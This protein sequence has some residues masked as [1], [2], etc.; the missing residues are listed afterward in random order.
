MTNPIDVKPT[1]DA[2]KKIKDD[3][4]YLLQ[5]FATVNQ[6]KGGGG[7]VETSV[8]QINSAFYAVNNGPIMSGDQHA[9]AAVGGMLAA[10]C[11][12]TN[13]HA[14]S[15]G[16][17]QGRWGGGNLCLIYEIDSQM[18]ETPAAWAELN[19]EI[20]LD[21]A[22]L[23]GVAVSEVNNELNTTAIPEVSSEPKHKG[24]RM[25]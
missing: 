9:R 4:G 6:N 17:G 16:D 15:G 10:F 3:V 24:P 13:M 18:N 21:E 20:D 7:G 12:N 8:E 2:L 22:E 19:I 23:N 11:K 1:Q 14:S 25:E 5:V